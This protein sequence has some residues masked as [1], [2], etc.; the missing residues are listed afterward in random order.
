MYSAKKWERSHGEQDAIIHTIPLEGLS[1]NGSTYTLRC[2]ICGDSK[3]DRSKKRGVFLWNENAQSYLYKCHNEGCKYNNKAKTLYNFLKIEYPMIWE[4]EYNQHEERKPVEY[5][6]YE[7]PIVDVD[8]IDGA[9]EF[10]IE[11]NMLFPVRDFYKYVSQT[12][13]Y[14]KQLDWVNE[15]LV[16]R[17]M[18]K[19]IVKDE[20]YIALNYHNDIYKVLESIK[21]EVE[22]A[23]HKDDEYYEEKDIYH[24]S[25]SDCRLVWFP[26]DENDNIVAVTARSLNPESDPKYRY[27]KQLLDCRHSAISGIEKIKFNKTVFITEGYLDSIFLENSCSIG[28]IGNWGQAIPRLYSLGVRDIVLVFDNESSTADKYMQV[29]SKSIIDLHIGAVLWDR[30]LRE[31]G[32]DVNEYVV[33]GIDIIDEIHNHTSYDLEKIIKYGLEE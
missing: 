22:N 2:P 10:F 20:F 26:R 4:A 9:I 27:R 19:D 3:K 1:R 16:M 28:G 29:I 5:V 7:K 18:P 15:F 31:D 23:I 32:K 6:K 13:K 24:S 21:I 14:E 8:D 30:E 25:K 33:K 12:G 11:E 17:Q